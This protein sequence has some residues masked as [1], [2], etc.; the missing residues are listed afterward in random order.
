MGKSPHEEWSGTVR[1]GE[2]KG[3]GAQSTGLAQE[4]RAPRGGWCASNL[5]SEANLGPTGI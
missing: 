2:K 4:A 3:G 1:S 5:P